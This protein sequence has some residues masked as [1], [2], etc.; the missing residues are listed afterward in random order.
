MKPQKTLFFL[1]LA[2]ALAACT[3]PTAAPTPTAA[4]PSLTP[5]PVLEP[6]PIE[7][8]TLSL[9]LDK[10]TYVLEERIR[11]TLTLR[12]VGG[13]FAFV[14]IRLAYNNPQ[15]PSNQSRDISFLIYD[16][17]G[18]PLEYGA[19]HQP[20]LLEPYHFAMFGP[21]SAFERTYPNIE[22]SYIFTGPGEYTIQALYEN[23]TDPSDGRTA[24]QG[25]I[26]SNI[27]TFTIE[28]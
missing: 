5:T 13:A 4:P 12:Y 18:K 7:D 16:Q 2:L 6:A 28:P 14:N 9:E 20:M 24:W 15:F 11:A 19:M 1:L 10:D 17:D 3:Q 25:Q 26:V 27:V 8:L 22:R 21:N 23:Y